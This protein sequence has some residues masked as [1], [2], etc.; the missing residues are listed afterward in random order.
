MLLK[1]GVA[2][3]LC[4]N[5]HDT[6]GACPAL[7]AHQPVPQGLYAGSDYPGDG[8][9]GCAWAPHTI[10]AYLRRVTNWQKRTKRPF[11]NDVVVD[12]RDWRAALPESI[13]AVF[14]PA[15]REINSALVALHGES[16]AAIE[17]GLSNDWDR[18]FFA[19][20]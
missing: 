16:A 18:P 14:G 17:V 1:P 11:Y 7:D 6:G 5:G 2:R 4:A 20:E 19:V 10:H 9:G 13:E 15:G 12:A 3:V 8:C